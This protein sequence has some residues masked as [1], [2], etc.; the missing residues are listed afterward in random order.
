VLVSSLDGGDFH[1]AACRKLLLSNTASVL[2]HALTETFSTLTGGR[3][4][5]RVSAA[6]AAMLI[7]TQLAPRLSITV[8]RS[9]DVLDAL[10]DSTRRGIRGGAI[11][12]YLHLLA[13]RKAGAKRIYTLNVTDFSQFHRPGDPE[14]VHP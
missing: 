12:D 14:I 13:A 9:E 10:D 2:S 6:D 8:L 7:R 4:A 11:Y 3:L 1:H 5:I